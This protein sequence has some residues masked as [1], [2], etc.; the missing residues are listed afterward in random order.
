VE[1]LLEVDAVT[2]ASGGPSGPHRLVHHS[3]GLNWTA[4]EARRQ[5]IARAMIT[6]AIAWAQES[7]A[8]QIHLWVTVGNDGAR[9][10]YESAGFQLTDDTQPLPS[11]P[12]KLMFRMRRSVQ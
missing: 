5:G 9:L 12:S 3:L 11:N 4:P 7:G 6:T 8:G 2:V 10:L 1:L